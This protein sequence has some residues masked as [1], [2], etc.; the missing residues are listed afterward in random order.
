MDKKS[1]LATAA[2]IR[3]HLGKG[4]DGQPGL[5]ALPRRSNESGNARAYFHT[6]E[7]AY[8]R[9]EP[10]YRLGVGIARSLIVGGEQT[11]KLS[12]RIACA[13]DLDLQPLCAAIV[14]L[15]RPNDPNF[16]EDDV[17]YKWVGVPKLHAIR[18][19]DRPGAH[20]RPGVTIRHGHPRTGSVG[21]VSCLVV[22]QAGQTHILTAGHA[23]TSFWN[24]GSGDELWRK[25]SKSGGQ[26]AVAAFG[27]GVPPPT[28]PEQILLNNEPMTLDYALAPV[29][30]AARCANTYP[31]R[32]MPALG[33]RIDPLD[34]TPVGKV[35]KFGYGTGAREG[36]AG[37]SDFISLPLLDSSRKSV[38][39]YH[40]LR[41]IVPDNK[42]FSAPGDSGALA[43]Q[44]GSGRI[45]GM[46]IGGGSADPL[47]YDGKLP[48]RVPSFALPLGPVLD[49]HQ[50]TV[51]I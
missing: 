34:H 38:V 48:D 28:G 50:L 33:A 9:Y 40:G 6:I 21:T 16:S 4:A 27:T 30:A 32:R 36:T 13:A 24:A 44:K 51:L 29:T 10:S 45:L 35:V 3:E 18:A 2:R 11:W 8:D 31:D 22:T 46:L 49:K 26:I 41:E 47:D 20:T 1:A 5:P 17:D 25:A 39:E 37:D 12:L 15:A 14:E 43:V 7:C 23:A 19:A 42:V